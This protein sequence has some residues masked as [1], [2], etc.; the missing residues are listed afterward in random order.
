M[1]YKNLYSMSL[2]PTNHHLCS[3]DLLTLK[4]CVLDDFLREKGNVIIK[5]I[6]KC[7]KEMAFFQFSHAKVNWEQFWWPCQSTVFN[8]EDPVNHF[9][10]ERSFFILKG[11][12]TWSP[13]FPTISQS[14]GKYHS[15]LSTFY[16]VA[17]GKGDFLFEWKSGWKPQILQVHCIA[18]RTNFR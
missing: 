18:G 11:C 7:W 4:Y 8:P 12:G 1:V 16:T 14:E 17:T 6:K 2:Q 5:K 13:Q 3:F 10:W 15:T 9:V